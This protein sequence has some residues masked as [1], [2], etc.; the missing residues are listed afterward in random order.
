MMSDTDL[1]HISHASDDI[2]SWLIARIAAYLKQPPEEIDPGASLA[3]YGL[4]SMAAF[5]LCADI[6]SELGVGVEPVLLWNVDTVTALTTHIADL[7]A[8]QSAR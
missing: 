7:M 3:E 5:S 6:E 2:R 8:G 1:T 4:D